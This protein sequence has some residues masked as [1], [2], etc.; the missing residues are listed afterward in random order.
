MKSPV[1]LCA[2]NDIILLE[3]LKNMGDPFLGGSF[4]GCLVDQLA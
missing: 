4:L 2:V 3:D 1:L